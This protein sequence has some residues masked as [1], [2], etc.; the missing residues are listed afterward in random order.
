MKK[1][2]DYDSN[3][4]LYT[5]KSGHTFNLKF[6]NGITIID[7]MSASGKT[8]LFND[9]KSLKN[10]NF[11]IAEYDVSNIEL[12]ENSDVCIKDDKVLYIVD[13]AERILTDKLCSDIVSCK[14]SRFLIFTRVSHNLH[15]SPN[16]FGEFN[17]V[18][19]ITNIKY[20]FNE[21]GWF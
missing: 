21:K 16:H 7:G 6:C 9:I 13:K 14:Y 18:D 2:Y 5:R 3:S 17:T 4:L 8:L 20:L 19:G 10:L 12:I 15:V 1:I 11:K